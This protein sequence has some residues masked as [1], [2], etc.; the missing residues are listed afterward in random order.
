MDERVDEARRR[1]AELRATP[2]DAQQ[3]VEQVPSRAS[4]M[5]DDERVR[6]TA[7]G[8]RLEGIEL[9][10]RVLRQNQ[11]ELESQLT[12]LINTA[13]AQCRPRP[14]DA[15]DVPPVDVNGLRA[16]LDAAL[17]EAR[18]GMQQVTSALGEAVAQINQRAVMRG[19][20]DP[21]DFEGL[22]AQT[23]AALD[24]VSP[25]TVEMAAE[26]WTMNNRVYAKATSVGHVS[27]IWWEP[28]AGTA[29][30]TDGLVQAVNT[31]LTDAAAQARQAGAP[32]ADHTERLNAV[33]DA[34]VAQLRGYVASLQALMSN[35]QPK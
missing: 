10:A 25:S 7:V 28:D 29:E 24:A 21:P 9:D 4:A 2:Q 30:I 31:A 11:V 15:Q 17:N 8:G 35:V 27:R 3:P 34:S 20:V 33:Q 32:S 12:R 26:V 16:S 1:L 22:F 14:R 5:S 19:T 18:V 6:V 23:R 13:L